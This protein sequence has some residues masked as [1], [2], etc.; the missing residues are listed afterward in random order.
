LVFRAG[1]FHQIVALVIG[2]WFWF[3]LHSHLT[4]VRNYLGQATPKVLSGK[5]PAGTT[6]TRQ[7]TPTVVRFIDTPKYGPS[8]LLG[9]FPR[10]QG[11]AHLGTASSTSATVI[12]DIYPWGSLALVAL[13]LFAITK[14]QTSGN[15]IRPDP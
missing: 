5:V 1:L 4:P 6:V 15:A 3:W 13:V 2:I 8:H 7:I 12:R 14:T 11:L 9:T 10:G